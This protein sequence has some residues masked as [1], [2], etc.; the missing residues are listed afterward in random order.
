[1]SQA[2]PEIGQEHDQPSRSVVIRWL[3]AN[4]ALMSF[5]TGV[6]VS[7]G[8]ALI[9]FGAWTSDYRHDLADQ[10]ALNLVATGRLDDAHKTFIDIDR[11]L[12]D[13]AQARYDDRRAA[14]RA[15]AEINNNRSENRRQLEREI[16]DLR[17]EV[18]VLKAQLRLFVDHLPASRIGIRSP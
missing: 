9:G 11:R 6:A 2:S 14:E 16:A 12:V 4:L 8:G 7:G 13:A 15:D 17:G 10:K 3:R 1:M 5:V 18:E